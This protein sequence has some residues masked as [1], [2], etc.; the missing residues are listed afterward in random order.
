MTT[1]GL[2]RR[3]ERLEAEDT[4]GDRE[5]IVIELP[6][7]MSHEEALTTLELERLRGTNRLWIFVSNFCGKP[8]LPRLASPA[9]LATPAASEMPTAS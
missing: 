2:H 7:G 1:R 9:S 5:P 3:V 4:I 6:H 8:G